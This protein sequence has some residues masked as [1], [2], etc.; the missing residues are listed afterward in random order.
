LLPSFHEIAH[1]LLKKPFHQGMSRADQSPIDPHNR[2]KSLIKVAFRPNLLPS[3]PS[4]P[5]LNHLASPASSERSSSLTIDQLQHYEECITNVSVIV[6]ASRDECLTLQGRL[7]VANAEL[8]VKDATIER[9]ISEKLQ[10]EHQLREHVATIANL[11]LKCSQHE[12][13]VNGRAIQDVTL[14][15]AA[16]D[17]HQKV[18]LEHDAQVTDFLAANE[19]KELENLQLRAIISKLEN[20]HKAFVFMQQASESQKRDLVLMQQSLQVSEKTIQSLKQALQEE[21]QISEQLSEKH[22]ALLACQSEQSEILRLQHALQ[23]SETNCNSLRFALEEERLLNQK[24][25]KV[26]HLLSANSTVSVASQSFVV[27]ELEAEK[28][29]SER[30]KAALEESTQINNRI[31]L[32]NN[33]YQAK[34]EDLSAQVMSCELCRWSHLLAWFD[35]P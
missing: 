34:V 15:Q 26:E 33:T 5:V 13:V 2:H 35:I 18:L 30:L 14:I 16:E 4:S 28:K 22:G 21:Q 1:D 12:E 19:A 25:G 7:D 17:R 3:V 27:A 32:A 9:M 8:G 11:N 10:L 23:L 20:E 31:L 29:L 24:F 6:S